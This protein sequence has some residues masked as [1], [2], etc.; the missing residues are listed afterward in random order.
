MKKLL[1]AVV[2]CLLSTGAFAQCNGVFA[3]N[4]VCGNVS[5]NAAPPYAAPLSS[6]AF[7]PGG[8]SGEVQTNN[9]SNGFA[10]IT[11]TQL[12]ALINLAT[13]SL[14]GA[15]P[16]W[17]N[18]ITTFFRGDGTYASIVYADLPTI[19]TSNIIGN[20]SGSTATPSAQA[21]P[22]CANDGLHSLTNNS[23]SGFNCTS[24]T[25]TAN[26][27]YTLSHQTGSWVCTGPSG[28]IINIGGS[29]TSGLQECINAM[30]TNK[31][32]NFRAVCPP[33]DGNVP[34]T[35][36]TTVT[37]GPNDGA[38]YDLRGCF[39]DSS[40][41]TGVDV[42]SL[43]FGSVLDWSAGEIYCTGATSYCV[44]LDPV[45]ATTSGVYGIGWS[46]LKFPAIVETCASTGGDDAAFYVDPGNTPAASSENA[47]IYG[48][49]IT[50]AA[51]DG[52]D[53]SHYCP[54]YGLYITN[55]INIYAAFGQNQMHIG[56]IQGV[57]TNYLEEGS[58]A[59]SQAT[60]AL[61]TNQWFIG[62]IGTN[63]SASYGILTYGFQDIWNANISVNGG[64]LTTGAS[65]GATT[66]NGN[67]FVIPQ[68]VG[69]GT[70]LSDSATSVKNYGFYAGGGYKTGGTF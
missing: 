16:A 3:N 30:Q 70:A 49:F 64:S 36:S 48:S 40:A 23:G 10:G 8:T 20:F 19:S 7:G 13:A 66:A 44:E 39:L 60:Q 45:H 68:I 56:Y 26:G 31:D 4:T 22:S 51:I 15:I 43:E 46:T 65:F 21:V 38:F 57:D 54:T 55:P 69:A 52:Y 2:L 41:T 61:G 25:S 37:F 9:G 24:I 67:W 53:G 6:F 58:G 18:N 62:S 5:G 34:I 1:L 33:F 27:F 32:G 50:I 29:T 35:A 59:V 63:G 11:N 42:D 14:S 47:A 17:P 28:T 12:T